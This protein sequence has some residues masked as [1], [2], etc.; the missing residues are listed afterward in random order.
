MA[1][2]LAEYLTSHAPCAVGAAVLGLSVAAAEIAARLSGHA[3][4]PALETEAS[5]AFAARLATTGVRFLASHPQHDI[6]EI[7]TT[8]SLAIALCPLDGAD[9]EANAASGTLFSIYPAAPGGAA[10]SFLR[11]GTDQLAAGYVL[12]GPR[13]ILAL[14][15]GQGMAMF[16]LA[17][18]NG[19]Y[20]CL[21]SDFRLS[22]GTIEFAANAADY[23]DWDPPVQRFVD[24]CLFSIEDR[25]V[26]E[27]QM[28]WT[29]SL[30]A[31]T[32]RILTH[33]GIYL[34]PR[35]TRAA[36]RLIYHCHPI[37]MLIEQAGG[38]AT[39]G[40]DRILDQSADALDISSPLV[41]GAPS[42]VAR[43]AAYHDLPD[44]EASPLFSRR[45]LFRL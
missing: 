31:D 4:G 38:Q 20:Q 34:A 23:R 37:A 35:G 18:D 41:F 5:N 2:N 13:T 44:A 25:T 15:T 33:G 40:Q 10:A 21:S 3:C 6:A 7:D 1:P 43:L 16:S 12:Y 32:Q 28:R 30:A 39:N 17:H 26:E 22:S 9:I 29:G 19:T 24:D 45:G 11:P 8:G 42:A 14:S 36:L 27:L